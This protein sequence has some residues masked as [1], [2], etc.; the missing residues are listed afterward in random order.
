MDAEFQPKP[1][2]EG[3]PS[4]TCWA[5][6]CLVFAAS[7]GFFGRDLGG[8]PHFIDESAYIAQAYYFDLLAAGAFDD[9]EWLAFPALDGPPLVKYLIGLALRIGG[10][11]RHG[12]SDISAWYV[13]QLYRPET[14]EALAAARWP[15]AILGALGCTA[16]FGLGVLMHGRLA[17]VIASLM[18]MVNP[19]YEMHARRAMC[20]VPAEALV[21]AT[22]AVAIWSWRRMLL[23][24]CGFLL[25]L[26]MALLVGVLGGLAALSKLSGML[27][28]MIVAA[29]AV[30]AAALRLVRPGRGGGAVVAAAFLSA[31][32][33]G[34]TFLVLNPFTT[35]RPASLPSAEMARRAEEGP[36]GRLVELIEHRHEFSHELMGRFP[37]VALPAAGDKLRAIATRGFGRYG[38]FGRANP[39]KV[40]D[41]GLGIDR[42][43]VVWGPW[44]LLGA[45]CAGVR[46]RRQ[47]L[48]GELP[49]AW[50]VLLAA[51]VA[52]L[53]IAAYIPIDWDRYYLPIQS[54][55]ALLAACAAAEAGRLLVPALSR[56]LAGARRR[57]ALSAVVGC[58]ALALVV[59]SA[60]SASP[61]GPREV[62]LSDLAWTVERNGWGPVERDDSNGERAAGD[63]RAI[64]LRGVTYAK[65]LGAHAGSEVRV[66]LGGAFSTFRS[67]IGLDDEAG[68]SGTVVFEV[69]AD[70]ERLYA[71][72]ALDGLSAIRAV[73]VDISGR[74]ELCLRVEDC[75]DGNHLDHADWAR[76]RLIPAPRRRVGPPTRHGPRRRAGPSIRPK[77]PAGH[78][79]GS[80]P[81]ARNAG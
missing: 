1:S 62:F 11:P 26:A 7:L 39:G 34:S 59:L 61:A 52:F 57:P 25:W 70:G 20:D 71:S 37:G 53:T 78:A 12:P 24:P 14:D 41:P 46:G 56:G 50:A 18:L 5:L 31:W 19:V 80:G 30:F 72:G 49:T 77:R 9:R 63:G 67:E 28:M 33:S 42:W 54:W 74:R 51:G 21:L 43:A 38:L 58:G 8:E 79:R 4:W 3:P 10:H 29:L 66:S 40:G 60:R 64:S 81:S 55:S 48:A 15:S 6:A 36:L 45:I 23:A 2:R 73:E 17:G 75:G 22:V 13:D 69:W 47:L 32:V 65:G 68:G 16:L 35:A 44:V 27:A 76:A